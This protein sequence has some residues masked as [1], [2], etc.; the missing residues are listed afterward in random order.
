[1]LDEYGCFIVEGATP[2]LDEYGCFAVEGLAPFG[3]MNMVVLSWR[4]CRLYRHVRQGWCDCGTRLQAD[5]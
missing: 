2:F 5:I 1:M 4:G 3:W